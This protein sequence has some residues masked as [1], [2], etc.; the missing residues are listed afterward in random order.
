MKSERMRNDVEEAL[1]CDARVAMWLADSMET[2][3]GLMLLRTLSMPDVRRLAVMPDVHPSKG[4]CVGTAFSTRELV[5]PAAIG[6]DIGCGMGTVRLR[7]DVEEI[8]GQEVLHVLGESVPV[9]VR[10]APAASAKGLA[11]MPAV[12]E[13]REERLRRIAERDGVLQLG[14]LGRGNHFVEL[15]RDEGGSLWIMVHSGSRAMGQAVAGHYARVAEREGRHAALDAV[16][17][18][19]A[20][21]QNYLSDQAWCVRYARANRTAM[22]ASAAAGLRRVLGVDAD[23]E[24]WMDVPHNLVA[25]EVHEGEEVLVHRKGAAPAHAGAA[26]MIPGSAGTMSVHVEGRGEARSLCTSSHGAGRLLSRSDAKRVVSARDVV[27]E[28]AG[29]VFDERR[30]HALR[31]ESPS[32]YRDLREVMRAQRELVKTTRTLRPVVSFKA[33]G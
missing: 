3:T 1:A 23:W 25:V 7:G 30:T 10:R 12:E 13:L 15:Q 28:M 17:R 27:R 8:D 21:G 16:E 18:S 2:A 31:D 11:R 19:S 14:T 4:V 6:G 29:V 22:L 33:A 26:G 9:M 5:Y 20:A 32:V 24:S